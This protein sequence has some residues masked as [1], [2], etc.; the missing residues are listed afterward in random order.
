MQARP[1]LESTTRFQSL[2]CEKGCHSAFNLNPLVCEPWF[3]CDEIARHYQ[4]GAVQTLAGPSV[5][6]SGVAAAYVDH[7]SDGG[8]VRFKVRR[9]KLDPGLKAPPRFQKFDCEKRIHS[10]FNLNPAVP[11]LAPLYIKA[12]GATALHFLGRSVVVVDRNDAGRTALRVVDTTTGATSTGWADSGAAASVGGATSG[13]VAF[14][15]D[16]A[17]LYFSDVD[18]HCVRKFSFNA[19]WG[20]ASSNK[21]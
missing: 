18:F 4:A 20:G 21:A 5:S 19:G 15:T 8:A 2:I 10:A 17:T 12:P 1:W 16:G 13:G 14:S 6:A 7:A 3:V 11:E 9:C